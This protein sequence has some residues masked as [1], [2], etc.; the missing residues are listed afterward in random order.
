MPDNT[1]KNLLTFIQLGYCHDHYRDRN[2]VDRL[3][4]H[5][6]ANIAKWPSVE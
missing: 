4:N 1:F 3:L 2:R 5:R 6:S